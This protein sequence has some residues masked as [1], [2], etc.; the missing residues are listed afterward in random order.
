MNKRTFLKLIGLLPV[1]SLLSSKYVYAQMGDRDYE[2]RD[3]RCPM[4]GGMM[5]RQGERIPIPDKLPTPENEQWVNNFREVYAL[6]KLSRAQYEA[7]SS[8]YG[9]NMPYHMIIRQEYNHIS[10]EGRMF[11][12]YGIPWDSSVPPLKQTSSLQDAY[13]VGYSLETDLIPRY[14]RLIVN[15]GDQ[16]SRD[17]LDFVLMQTRMHAT[18]FQHVMRMGGMGTGMG[19]G[20]MH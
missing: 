19:H 9:V 3:G 11:S 20:M 12:A 10:W 5:G 15:A 14:E 7:D 18:M 8:K 6:E 2:W 1:F 17:I 4:C 16:T 13:Q